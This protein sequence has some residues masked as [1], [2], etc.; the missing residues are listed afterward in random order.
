MARYGMVVDTRQCI[1]CEDCVVAC[2]VENDVPP[3]QRRDRVRPQLEGRFPDLKLTFFSERCNHCDN[4][5][6]V[7]VCPTQAS[8]VA[9]PGRTVQIDYEKCIKCQLCL[10]A[11]PYGARFMNELKEGKA[12][13]CT[14]CAHRL[15]EGKDPACVAVCPARAMSFGDLDDPAS[16]VSELLRTRS[17]QVLKPEAGTKPRVFYLA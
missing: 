13:K 11:C 14:F 17:H 3:G 7:A 5:P 9:E 6:C 1:G 2:N 12:D 10:Q 15:A 16:R 8:H 4:P